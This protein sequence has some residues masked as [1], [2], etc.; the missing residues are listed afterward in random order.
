VIKLNVIRTTVMRG[1]PPGRTIAVRLWK[2]HTFL[3]FASPPSKKKCKNVGLFPKSHTFALTTFLAA[4]VILIFSAICHTCPTSS[5]AWLP[6]PM[7]LS[8]L[9]DDDDDDDLVFLY[10]FPAGIFVFRLLGCSFMFCFWYEI[11]CDFEKG[12]DFAHVGQLVG[13]CR[14]TG[15]KK[16]YKKSDILSESD[17]FVCGHPLLND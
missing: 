2:S 16:K 14:W 12:L 3:Q 1:C 11:P 17:K 15:N 9:P 8:F 7:S 5:V 6:D 10:L 4:K 13:Q